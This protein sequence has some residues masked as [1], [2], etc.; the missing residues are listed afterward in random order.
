M[1]TSK[2]DEEMKKLVASINEYKNM[3]K[4]KFWSYFLG[5]IIQS[6]PNFSKSTVNL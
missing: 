4:L 3:K 1:K 6:Q 5:A 2:D